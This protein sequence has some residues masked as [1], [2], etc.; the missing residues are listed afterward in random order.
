MSMAPNISS[1]EAPRRRS[2]LPQE[3]VQKL[4]AIAKA[5]RNPALQAGFFLSHVLRAEGHLLSE[6]KIE[7]FVEGPS[8]PIGS[9]FVSGRRTAREDNNMEVA[10]AIMYYIRDK[11]GDR[12]LYTDILDFLWSGREACSD[13]TVADVGRTITAAEEGRL[14][15]A[16]AD[17]RGV[18]AAAAG[19]EDV[20]ATAAGSR[21]EEE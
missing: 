3:T 14:G 16:E 12:Y 7:L 9:I 4:E 21:Q 11:Y 18:A 15:V 8:G 17:D 6:R 19:P 5:S 1:V 20:S 10:H 13:I 2:L